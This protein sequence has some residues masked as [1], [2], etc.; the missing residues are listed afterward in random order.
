MLDNG[1]KTYSYDPFK[2]GLV[3]LEGKNLASGNTL[4][5]RNEALV[6]ERLATAPHV[7]VLGRSL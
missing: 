4:F 6:R 3:S 1:F 7:V 2:R 5:I